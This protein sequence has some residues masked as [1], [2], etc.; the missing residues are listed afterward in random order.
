[1]SE[2]FRNGAPA[3]LW[4]ALVQE[5]GERAGQR[6]DEWREAHLVFVLLRYQR[7]GELL[8][9]TQA[10]AWLHAHAQAGQWRN[11]CLQRVGDECL[12]IAGMFPAL[13]Q[14][15]RVSVDYFIELGRGA[16]HE[17]AEHSGRETSSF[18]GMLARSYR[19]LVLVLR[20]LRKVP[21]PLVLGSSPVS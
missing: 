1:M 19:Q 6:L 14:R 18:Y 10:L 5:A 15:R 3:E 20:Q 2:A 9:H 11:E 7:E 8:S 13:A 4:Q 12:L 16:Y 21:G 17:V